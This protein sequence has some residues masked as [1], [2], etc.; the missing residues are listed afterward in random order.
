MRGVHPPP[1]LL[2][3][4]EQLVGHRQSR[5]PRPGALRDALA[6]PDRGEGG[7]DRVRGAQV[8]VVLGR[9]VVE[10]EQPLEV[11]GDLRCRLRPLRELPGEGARRIQRPGARRGSRDGVERPR[12]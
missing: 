2:R 4:V 11:V 9:E 10:R 8:H 12:R 3:G 6:Q 7:L 5:R 1:A